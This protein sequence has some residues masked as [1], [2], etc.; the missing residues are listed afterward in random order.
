MR[1]SA[2]SAA[3]TAISPRLPRLSS[4]SPNRGAAFISSTTRIAP[5]GETSAMVWRME[6]E[7]MS[8]ADTRISPSLFGEGELSVRCGFWDEAIAQS[9]RSD[10]DNE[11]SAALRLMALPPAGVPDPAVD[12]DERVDVLVRSERQLEHAEVPVHLNDGVAREWV[13]HSAE[14]APARAGNNLLY[15]PR[16]VGR[17][18]RILRQKSLVVVLV[19]GKHELHAGVVKDPPQR[20]HLGRGAVVAGVE[21]RAVEICERAFSRV[22]G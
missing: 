11:T 2:T 15:A 12:I 21:Q 13:T 6:F 3:C 20:S 1:V 17:T 9:C 16:R 10:P 22:R 18:I 4:P 7:P 14:V 19:T 8:I 5:V